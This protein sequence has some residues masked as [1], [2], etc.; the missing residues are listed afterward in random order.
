MKIST[1][2]IQ[3]FITGSEFYV[4]A[5][6]IDTVKND[7]LYAAKDNEEAE[8]IY[9]NCLSYCKN[10]EIYF[11]PA[12][13][14]QPYD[15]L[16]PSKKIMAQRAQT[17]ASLALNPQL[18]KKIV[19]TTISTLL[20]KIPTPEV[21]LGSV[22]TFKIQDTYDPQALINYLIDHNYLRSS[23]ASNTGEFA[24]RGS[25]IDV[26]TDESGCGY[27][28][29]FLGKSIDSIK[30]YDTDTQMSVSQEHFVTITP[31]SELILS[32]TNIDYFKTSIVRQ[33]GARALD[34]PIMEKITRGQYYSVGIEQYLPLF[35]RQL[36]TIFD[37]LNNPVLALNPQTEYL[38]QVRQ[39]DIEQ[40]HQLRVE[41]TE[42]NK[43]K[44]AFL[45]VDQL[46]HPFSN[47]NFIA[48]EQYAGI[49][50]RLTNQENLSLQAG[51]QKTTPLKLLG[52]LLQKAH[53]PYLLGC[54]SIGSRERI[55]R[56]LKDHEINFYSIDDWHSKNETALNT[57]ALGLVILDLDAAFGTEQF[58]LIP[59]Q[60]I[61]GEKIHN[62]RI[63]KRKNFQQL[64]KEAN[65]FV[66]GQIVVHIDHG[67]GRFEGLEAIELQNV[68][69][70]CVKIVYDGGDILYVPVEN[71]ESIS[72]YGL[73]GEVRLDK[74]G[75]SAWQARKAK[76][77]NR[78]KLSAQYLIKIAAD[79][80]TEQA[81]II[82]PEPILYDEFCATFPYRE[83]DDQLN[84]IEA[85]LED[86][87]SGKAMDRLVCGD[88]GFGKTE[89]AMRAV[90][91]VLKA[92]DHVR[93]Q[94]AVICPTTLLCRQHFKSFSERLKPFNI[95]VRQLSR[96][97]S[98]KEANKIVDE[99]NNGEVDL[100]IC[101]H[102]LL[103]KRL[104]FK[105]LGLIVVDEE[106]HFGVSQKER[107]K[108]KSIGVHVLSLSATPIPRTLQ[109]SLTG[110][111]DLSVIATP[112]MNR[113]VTK[114]TVMAYDALI[115]KE[116]I[117]RE[118]SNDG[119]VFYVCPRIS[120]LKDVEN[121]IQNL[122]PNLRYV[123]A[124]GQMPTAKL[125]KIMQDFYDH[126]YDILVSTTIIESGLDLANANTIIIHR[127]DK[128]GLSQLYQLRGRVGRSTH[129]SYAYFT[130]PGHNLQPTVLTRLEILQ[131]I[132][133]LG[134]GFS[135][136]SHDMDIRGFGN[137]LGD[138]QSGHIN[139]VGIELY[140]DMLQQAIASLTAHQSLNTSEEELP[141][142]PQINLGV[143]ILIPEAYVPDLD[144][145]LLLYKRMS[146]LN[147]EMEIES[148]AAEMID[149]F[150]PLPEE[151]NDLIAIVK[152]KKLCLQ[153]HIKKIDAGPKAIMLEFCSQKFSNSDRLL[154]L[155]K[156]SSGKIKVR[157]DNKILLMY[158]V[159]AE[160]RIEII[161]R[162]IKRLDD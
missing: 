113:L 57:Q 90:F 9:N 82:H 71:I 154:A 129:R 87:A 3:P 84:S 157:P 63:K 10:C 66:V 161:E 144:L 141:W 20:Q 38:L 151:F 105:N 74:L 31:P 138:E 35:Y 91:A 94:V 78:I 32:Q 70:D 97:V 53:L 150:G 47:C 42:H 24:V 92:D 114:T 88:V 119:Q 11:L 52:E 28:I 133:S 81:A 158:A 60:D 100:V 8:L 162:F 128:F 58:I 30:K 108:E 132:D 136:A 13:D 6:I 40:C 110:I 103:N 137:L 56:I 4:L 68:K 25:I 134:A 50:K 153:H 95:K 149:R 99:L 155:V 120:D 21:I 109:M 86:L 73:E 111:K 102:S 112:P 156:N 49:I 18:S 17:L 148:F 54:M 1:I 122:V 64:V 19:I 139:E 26:V 130:I 96:F 83:T 118:C 117:I 123:V 16:S 98:S 124:H 140:Q 131:N 22:K 160:K 29:D 101:T 37:Y 62:I 41:E 2:N 146:D 159:E 77:R 55:M 36:V 46:Y 79:R 127:A 121:I 152:L 67:I 135:V 7:V 125:E 5:K 89:V 14:V 107:F 85:I 104:K 23:N 33:Y 116:A 39:N 80:A 65:N 145:R 43:S 69:H 59:E 106:Q 12:W 51:L 61:F 93:R 48:N 44:T 34:F 75:H 72:R 76:M 147:D 27:R 142:I 143:S 45:P 115:I 15:F 126:K